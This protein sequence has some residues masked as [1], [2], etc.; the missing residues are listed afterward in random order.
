MESWWERAQIQFAEAE[1]PPP[2]QGSQSHIHS[3]PSGVGLPWVLINIRHPQGCTGVGR[4]LGQGAE[5]ALVLQDSR[6]VLLKLAV[7][8]D[9]WSPNFSDHH[10]P[11]NLLKCGFLGLTQFGTSGVGPRNQHFDKFF[12]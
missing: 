10:Y 3:Q 2:P 1:S 9:Q 11:E 6:S 8:L 4:G 7:L 5:P 12:S